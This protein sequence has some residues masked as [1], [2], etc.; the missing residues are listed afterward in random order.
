MQYSKYY[1]LK[2]SKCTTGNR[3]HRQWILMASKEQKLITE[4]ALNIKLY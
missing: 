4:G 1:S 3:L 2:L